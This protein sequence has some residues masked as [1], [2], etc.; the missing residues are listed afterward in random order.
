MIGDGE[1]H[2]ALEKVWILAPTS[3]GYQLPVMLASKS[4][5]TYPHT[6]THAHTYNLKKNKKL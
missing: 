6:D 2:D 5:C 1:A 4:T 3:H